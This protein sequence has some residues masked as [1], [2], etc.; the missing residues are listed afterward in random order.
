MNRRVPSLPLRGSDPTLLEVQLSE[1]LR[2]P[3][4][5]IALVNVMDLIE[6]AN[7]PGRPRSL[8]RALHAFVDGV[9]RQVADIPKGRSWEDFL[10]DLNQLSG[11]QVPLAFRTMLAMEAEEP[12]RAGTRVRAMLERWEPE[13]PDAFSLNTTAAR[14]QRAEMVQP[15]APASEPSSAPRERGE[16]RARTPRESKPAA[17]KAPGAAAGRAKPVVDIDRRD[18]IVG[19]CLERLARTSDKGLAET[20][21]VAGVRH[22]AREAYADLTPLDVTTVLKQLKESNRVRYSAGRWALVTRF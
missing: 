20:V 13:P 8:D 12:E 17:P 9:R 3:I 19:Q 2:R 7:T 5:Q 11:R 4:G 10:E 14:I 15:R 1:L 21:L 6:L 16:G 22:A 18:F